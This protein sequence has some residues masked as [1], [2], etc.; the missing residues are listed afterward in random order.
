MMNLNTPGVLRLY[1]LWLC[2]SMFNSSEKKIID[3]YE[4]TPLT[5]ITPFGDSNLIGI[6]II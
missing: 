4:M 2:K 5:P 3:Q 6:K 1:F